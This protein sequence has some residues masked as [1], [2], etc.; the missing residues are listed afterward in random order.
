M[1][2]IVVLYQKIKN[3]LEVRLGRLPEGAKLP[4]LRQLAHQLDCSIGPVQRAVNE[5]CLEEKL[6]KIQGNGIFKK[7]TDRT[8]RIAILAGGL[9]NSFSAALV[10]AVQESLS[11]CE[12]VF[13]Y[14][15]DT[16]NCLEGERLALEQA[17]EL[18][19]AGIIFKVSDDSIKNDLLTEVSQKMPVVVLDGNLET[20]NADNVLSDD[21]TGSYKAVSTLISLGHTKI[22]Y[23][24]PVTEKCNSKLRRLG[25]IKALEDA[26]IAVDSTLVFQSPKVDCSHAFAEMLNSTE[27]ITAVACYSDDMALSV[28]EHMERCG[29]RV[30]TDYSVFG[31]GNEYTL[32]GNAV[33]LSTVDQNIPKM[34]Q[35]A[36]QCLMDRINDPR[37]RISEIKIPVELVINKSISVR[38]RIQPSKQMA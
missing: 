14:L 3:E 33:S 36:V 12:N 35:V 26:G 25:Y 19:S 30:P 20:V 5:L 23:F 18:K 7:K 15:L 8:V 13:Y 37:R 21:F 9:D 29:L 16:R 27:A 32:G 10:H 6:T 31:Y 1:A 11:D 28:M 24:A 2:D 4:S 17:I 22:A 38:A 34:G